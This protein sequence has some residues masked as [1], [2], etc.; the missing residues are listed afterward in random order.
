MRSGNLLAYLANRILWAGF[1]VVCVTLM[2]FIVT[3][4]IPA[5]PARAAAGLE[6]QDSQ[7]EEMRHRMGLDRPLYE[8]YLHYVAG[9]VRGD[10]GI[11][12]RSQRPVRDEIMERL[13]ATIE[14]VLA[15]MVMATV[16]GIPMGIAAALRRGGPADRLIQAG[17]LAGMAMPQFWLALVLQIVFFLDLRWLPAGG[18]FGLNSRPPAT[19]SGLYVFDALLTA[20]APALRTAL[21]YLLLPALT[22][23]LGSLANI[24]QITRRSVLEILSREYVRTARAKG[25]A[26]RAILSRHVLT[27]AGVPILTI[28][29]LQAGFLFSGTVLV[30]VVF[31]WPGIGKYAV[32]AI[33]YLDLKPMMAVALV[34][35]VLFVF[36]NFLVDVGY[37]LVDPRIRY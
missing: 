9:L 29:G 23:C 1:V 25:L 35:A 32:D 16:L 27:N 24:V 19:L 3:N 8:Q 14:L 22:L 31:S 4:V 36:I 26:G 17:A 13:P 5:D 12:G 2:T 28:L 15:A 6:A 11:A 18:R 7:V 33:A 30:E 21:A 37:A 10:W 20:N 34:I